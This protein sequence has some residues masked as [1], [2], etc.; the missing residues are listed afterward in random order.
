M[1]GLN[2]YKKTVVVVVLESQHPDE[3]LCRRGIRNYAVSAERVDR[4]D[5][6]LN[7]MAEERSS[8][9]W[10]IRCGNGV[11]PRGPGKPTSPCEV[12]SRTK[13]LGGGC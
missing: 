1:A 11:S 12:V 7:M 2:V 9:R 8:I 13:K 6:I 3:S 10:V 4:V 5:M